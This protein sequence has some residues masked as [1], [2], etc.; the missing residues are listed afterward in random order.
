M[1]FDKELM[2]VII[3]EPKNWELDNLNH[4]MITLEH[5]WDPDTINNK[6]EITV[7]LP[8]KDDVYDNLYE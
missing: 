1:N 6:L 4:V 3:Q 5:T 7:I 8:E 2:Y